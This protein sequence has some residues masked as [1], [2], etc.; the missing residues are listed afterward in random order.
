MFAIV[1]LALRWNSYHDIVRGDAIYEGIVAQEILKGHGFATR[2]MPLGAFHGQESLFDLNNQPNWP[3]QHKF[4]GSQL[5]IAI[6]ASILNYQFTPEFLRN[7]SYLFTC[8]TILIVVFILSSKLPYPIGLVAALFPIFDYRFHQ[9]GTWGTGISTDVF[10]FLCIYLMAQRHFF[11][12]SQ[13]WPA[14]LGLCSGLGICHRYSMV[15]WLP[16]WLVVALLPLNY[17]HASLSKVSKTSLY[18]ILGCAVCLAPLFSYSFYHFAKFF[19]S[20]LSDALWLHKTHFLPIDPWYTSQ[21]PSLWTSMLNEP[22][23]FVDKFTENLRAFISLLDEKM[24]L[25][26]FLFTVGSFTSIRRNPL[27]ILCIIYFA[28][29]L[30]QSLALSST[31]EYHFFILPILWLVMGLGLE[32]TVSILEH[33]EGMEFLV[34]LRAPN[35]KLLY[36]VIFTILLSGFMTELNTLSQYSSWK[37]ADQIENSEEIITYINSLNLPPSS[38]VIGGDRPWEIALETQVRVIPLP[39]RISE[40]DYLKNQGLSI[41]HILIP[42]DVGYFGDG[43]VPEDLSAWRSM[44]IRK[45]SDISGYSLKHIFMNGSILLSRDVTLTRNYNS[46]N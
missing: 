22:I 7:A 42:Y 17:S 6:L 5:R 10:I 45:V 25:M 29:W 36:I 40:I 35:V 12:P 41:S 43:G 38:V 14:L 15:F 31:P 39:A 21:W 16:F 26:I 46:E 34:K 2:L 13:I 27:S 24:L 18:F 37:K 9:V 20:Y 30:A 19:P 1:V 23:I 33:Q 3:S 32:K 44:V 11:H 4:L 28:I 8:L